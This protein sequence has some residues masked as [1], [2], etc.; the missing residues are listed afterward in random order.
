MRGH[1]CGIDVVE[2][3]PQPC[4]G[5]GNERSDYANR[6]SGDEWQGEVAERSVPDLGST[7]D[8]DG[9]Q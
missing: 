1:R 3:H 6:D 2:P 4:T 5:K 7:F 8:A 9:E